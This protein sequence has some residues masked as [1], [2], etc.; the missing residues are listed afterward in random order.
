MFDNN[1][2]IGVFDSGLGGI[3]VLKDLIQLLPQENFIYFADSGNC[4]YGEKEKNEIYELSKKITQ[5]LIENQCKIIVIACNTAT[6]AAIETLRKEFIFIDFVG[7]EPAIK[8]AALNT[9]TGKVGVL[10]TKNTLKGELFQKTKKKFAQNIEVLMQIGFGLVELVEEDKLESKECYQ[11]LE[12]YLGNMLADNADQIVLGCTH[13]PFLI[14]TIKK[15]IGNKAQ[16]LNPAIAVARQTEKKL[17]NKDLLNKSNLS[18]KYQFYT[19]GNLEILQ[20]FVAKHINL[21]MNEVSFFY[22]Y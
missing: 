8:P 16:I 19:T 11:L 1:S 2:P 20:N 22:K 15:I 21:E 10:A 3:S 17:E 13:Y 4:P 14:P 6:S 18:K 9:K 12:K 5:F 7:I